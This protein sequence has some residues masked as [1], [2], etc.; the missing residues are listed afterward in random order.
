MQLCSNATSGGT[1]YEAAV[2]LFRRRLGSSTVHA[3]G[4]D[5][6]AF[7]LRRARR[8][9]VLRQSRA[10]SPEDE[11]AWANDICRA[12]RERRRQHKRAEARHPTVRHLHASKFANAILRFGA[13]DASAG[14]QEPRARR[15]DQ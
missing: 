12:G 9:S 5:E 6:R 2:S 11:R 3:F 15:V 1:R 14:M 10:P 8:K 7:A 4:K 13:P